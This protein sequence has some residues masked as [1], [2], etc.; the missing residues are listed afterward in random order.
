MNRENFGSPSDSPVL[1]GL[2]VMIF[3]AAFYFTRCRK[4]NPIL[5]MLVCGVL[6]LIFY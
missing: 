3:L 2:S 1:F 5:V 6:G 4:T